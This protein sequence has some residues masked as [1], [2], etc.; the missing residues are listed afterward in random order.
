MKQVSI[1]VLTVA[2]LTFGACKNGSNNA[3][4]TLGVGAGSAAG[5]VPPG[6]AQSAVMSDTT[7]AGARAMRDSAAP[8]GTAA[9][10]PSDTARRVKAPSKKKPR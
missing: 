5:Q 7:A 2:A 1:A 8:S 4:D 10:S 3:S 9:T 6:G